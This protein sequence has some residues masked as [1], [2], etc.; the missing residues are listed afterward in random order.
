[1]Q[2][3]GIDNAKYCLLCVGGFSMKWRVVDSDSLLSS[4]I[5]VCHYFYQN[6]MLTVHSS[7]SYLIQSQSRQQ[8]NIRLHQGRGLLS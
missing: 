8:L 6:L 5:A 7:L 4:S 1:M 3:P 2:V